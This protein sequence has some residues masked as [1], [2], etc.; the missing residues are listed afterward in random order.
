MTEQEKLFNENINI[1][2]KV[3]HRF[4]DKISNEVREDFIQE[5]LIGLWYACENFD[6]SKGYKFSTYAYSLCSGYIMKCSTHL[7]TRRER[8]VIKYNELD[9]TKVS[10]SQEMFRGEED[11]QTVGDLLKDKESYREEDDMCANMD[12]K[13]FINSDTL[14]DRERTIFL[15]ISDEVT[16]TEIGERLGLAQ[17]HISR[18]YKKIK[19]KYVEWLEQEKM[20]EV[21]AEERRRLNKDSE[22]EQRLSTCQA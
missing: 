9:I 1:A 12:F 21:Y 3:A 14:T 10:M 20:G 17:A 6:E 19:K 13:R 4:A 22:E 7:S 2:Y 15:L 8:K 18:L 5:S 16:Q 11:I